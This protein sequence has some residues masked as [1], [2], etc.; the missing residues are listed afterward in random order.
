MRVTQ[1]ITVLGL[2]LGAALLMSALSSGLQDADRDPQQS[3]VLNFAILQTVSTTGEKR[4]IPA[5][6]IKKI[7]LLTEER[8]R[9]RIEVSYENGDYS[10]MEIADFH[11]IRASLNGSVPSVDVPV[12]RTGVDGMAFPEFKT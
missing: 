1:P 4:D 3:T 2:F 5:S 8:G 11:V 6:T 7:W 12:Q 10:S 9:L